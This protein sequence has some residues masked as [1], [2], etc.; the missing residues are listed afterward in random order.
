M[1]LAAVPLP[2]AFTMAGLEPATRNASVRERMT[3]FSLAHRPQKSIAAQTR[4]DWVAGS[5]AGHG[6]I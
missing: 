5:E 6:E 2:V 3:F 4:G 1:T